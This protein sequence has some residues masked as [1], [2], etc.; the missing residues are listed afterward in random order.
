MTLTPEHEAMIADKIRIA[1][2][3]APTSP[4][5]GFLAVTRHLKRSGAST[6]RNICTLNSHPCPLK[7]LKH[8]VG[9]LIAVVDADAAA[10]AMSSEVRRMAAVDQGVEK[11]LRDEAKEKEQLYRG[12]RSKRIR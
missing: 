12:M 1:L 9:P 10:A 6:L 5:T 8:I 4:P 11:S 7:T 3:D 2:P